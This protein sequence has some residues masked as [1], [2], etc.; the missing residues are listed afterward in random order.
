MKRHHNLWLTAIM[1]VQSLYFLW[2]IW[3]IKQHEIGMVGTIVVVVAYLFTVMSFDLQV[4]HP[5]ASKILRH[6]TILFLLA[7]CYMLG[8]V[9]KWDVGHWLM[10]PLSLFFKV[11]R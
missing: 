3:V 6:L 2:Y 1:I 8:I 10:M 5:S 9:T 7:S 4:N 11:I